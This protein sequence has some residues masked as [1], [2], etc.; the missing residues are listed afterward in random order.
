MR[1]STFTFPGASVETEGRASTQGHEVGMDESYGGW[2]YGMHISSIDVL[3]STEGLC[4]FF[5]SF[6]VSCRLEHPRTG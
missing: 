3:P 4:G 1:Q 6:G 2:R 5:M